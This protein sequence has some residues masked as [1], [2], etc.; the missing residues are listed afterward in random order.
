MI[1]NVDDDHAHDLVTRRSI[2]VILVMLNITPIIWISK[3]QK[4]VNT[5]T[6]RSESVASRV[7]TELILEI[8]YMF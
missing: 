7:P 6:Y 8:R 4:T 5:L 3:I 2:T 1:V